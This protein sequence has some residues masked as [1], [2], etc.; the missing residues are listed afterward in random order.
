MTCIPS[1][2]TSP[3]KMRLR[4][5]FA[6]WKKSEETG[7]WSSEM[8]AANASFLSKAKEPQAFQEPQK[9]MIILITHSV[10]R[11]AAE[12]RLKHQA[13]WSGTWA[14][15]AFQAGLPA[16]GA[17]ED[18]HSAAFQME[19]SGLLGQPYNNTAVDVSQCFDPILRHLLHMLMRFTSA[20]ETFSALI[21][22]CLQTSPS[23]TRLPGVLADRTNTHAAC[24]RGARSPW[25]SSLAV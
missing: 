22:A 8:L 20:A 14:D 4:S 13:E 15:A 3:Q 17:E 5:S 25:S 16:N 10:N 18:F 12:T 1:I 9:Q 11:T 2:P 21:A 7:D 6:S 24:L 19:L 23:T